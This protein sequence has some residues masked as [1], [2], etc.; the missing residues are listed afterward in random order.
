MK[1]IHALIVLVAFAP[2]VVAGESG[3]LLFEDD[4][5]R[6]EADPAVE[7]VGNGWKTNSKARAAG[8]KQV[9]VKNG[10]MHIARHA[11]ADHGVSVV[12]PAEFRDGT[13]ELRFKLEDPKDTLGID[14]A[15]PQ[16]KDVH[17]G[18]L[19]KV[20]VGTKRV[21]ISDLKTGNMNMKYYEAKKAKTLTDEQKTAI[22]AA[23]KQIPMN[24][25]SG[26]WHTLRFTIAGDTVTATIDGTDVG[27]FTSP[28]FAHPT[29][30]LLR[31]AVPKN[32]VV[33]DVKVWA[34][35]PTAK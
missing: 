9:W 23:N 19:L 11:V 21:Q 1:T 16:F 27:A 32:A 34:N 29:K 15:D 13:I 24:I 17:A 20:D 7:T 22:A 31:L 14:I 30:K 35:T 10:A 6:A 33:D 8:N 5:E 26:Q 12:H 4:F 3:K 2:A 18:H 25:E 28:G